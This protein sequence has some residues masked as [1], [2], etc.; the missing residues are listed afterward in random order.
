MFYNAR[1]YDPALG[2]F[3]QADTI[4]PDG[5]Q[6]MDRYAYVRNNP[7]IYTDPSGHIWQCVGANQDYCYDDGE[8]TRSG[9]ALPTS[10]YLNEIAREY[11][12]NLAPGDKWEYTESIIIGGKTALGLAPDKPNDLYIDASGTQHPADESS[13]Y[14]TN[15]LFKSCDTTDCVAGIM[16]HEATH[17]WVESKIEATGQQRNDTDV[18]LA[19]A[20]EVSADLVAIT[21]IGDPTGMITDHKNNQLN[22]YTD[23]RTTSK[24]LEDFYRIDLSDIFFLVYGR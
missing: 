13:V 5:V 19:A 7:M 22:Y 16:A 10:A 21:G 3:A 1:W 20:E 15:D 12:I 2:R 17:S 18:T 4:T 11:N 8:G 23:P 9:M 24:Y 14:I 6:G